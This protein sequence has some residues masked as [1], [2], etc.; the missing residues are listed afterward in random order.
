M[1]RRS[2]PLLCSTATG[3]SFGPQQPTGRT[4]WVGERAR[5]RG[6]T[7]SWDTRGLMVEPR[8]T[9]RGGWS[10]GALA[11]PA[12]SLDTI[13]WAGRDEDEDSI[14]AIRHSLLRDMA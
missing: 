10:A 12:W 2:R 4:A 14:E 8:M 13:D 1:F 11:C 9:T 7:A 5:E 6:C 3:T